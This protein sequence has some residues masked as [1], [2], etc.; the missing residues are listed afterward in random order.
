[1]IL[2][3]YH[4]VQLDQFGVVGQMEHL[5]FSFDDSPPCLVV[6][7]GLLVGLHGVPDL[8]VR[9]GDLMHHSIGPFSELGPNLEVQDPLPTGCPQL[10]RSSLRSFLRLEIVPDTVAVLLLDD[11]M[12]HFFLVLVQVYEIKALAFVAVLGFHF[13]LPDFC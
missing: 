2:G 3:L 10:L 4:L 9:V 1:M 7:L 5:Y 11:H 13:I 12:G 8:R 6:H